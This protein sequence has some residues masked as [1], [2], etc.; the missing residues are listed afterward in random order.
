MKE[1]LVNTKNSRKLSDNPTTIIKRF[2]QYVKDTE[3]VIEYYSKLGVVTKID[4]KR[5]IEIVYGDVKKKMS[6][7][8]YRC[9]NQT[10]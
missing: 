5:P 9:L 7:F 2:L 8:G 1:R 4:S 6:E 3:P 10:N